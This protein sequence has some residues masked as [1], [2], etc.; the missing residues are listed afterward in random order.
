M[1]TRRK[2]DTEFKLEVVRM[3]K[4]QHLPVS[5]VGQTTVVVKLVVA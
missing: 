3:V 2:F 5:E 4:D 1:K